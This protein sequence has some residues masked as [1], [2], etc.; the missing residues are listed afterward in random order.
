MNDYEQMLLVDKAKK[1]IEGLRE[2]TEVGAQWRKTIFDAHVKEGFT[3]QQ[4]MTITLHLT[5]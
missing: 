1:D 5:S 3:E 4:A 2:T